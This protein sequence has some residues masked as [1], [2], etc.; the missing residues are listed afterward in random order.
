MIAKQHQTIIDLAI[1]SCGSAEAAFELALLNGVSIT[2]EIAVGETV[3][4]PSVQDVDV[5]NYYTQKAICPATSVGVI[6]DLVAGVVDSYIS[7]ESL[8][9]ND[10][11]IVL[12][13]QNFIDL[14]TFYCGSPDLAA[15]FALLNGLTVTDTLEAGIKLKKP[16]VSNKKVQAYFAQKNIHPATDIDITS[17][18]GSAVELAGIGYWAIEVDFIIS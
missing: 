4:T 13:G 12:D 16:A 17:D 18:A 7:Y 5:L 3:Y 1:Q 15:E 9:Q 2:D 8:L 14:A 11:V 10:E 6:P